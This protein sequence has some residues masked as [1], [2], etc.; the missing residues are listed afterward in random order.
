MLSASAHEAAIRQLLG[1]GPQSSRALQQQLGLSQP[2]VSR[3]LAALGNELLRLGSGRSSF[4]SLRDSWPEL[5]RLPLRRVCEAGRLHA[6][7][8]L[9]P[10]RPA[11]FAVAAADG[12]VRPSD[13]LPW[14]LADLRPQGFLGRAFAQRHAAALGL[15]AD[16][17]AW[18]DRQ[19]LRALAT[20]GHDAVGNLLVGDAAR[21]QFLALPPPQAVPSRQRGAVFA[22]RAAQALAGDVPGSSAGGE[23]PKFTRTW[24][25]PDGTLRPEL[26]KF[27][28]PVDAP[29][30]RRWADLLIAEHLAHVTL[31][32]AGLPA[33]TSR[34]VTA[35]GR[36][37]LC[38]DRFDRV[39]ARGRRGVASL[40]ALDDG[41]GHD[42]GRWTTV[43]A[44]LVATGRVAAAVHAQAAWLQAFGDAIANTDMHLGNLSLLTQGDRLEGLAPV[45]DMLPM[46][47]APR[48]GGEVLPDRWRPPTDLPADVAAAARHFWRRAADDERVSEAYRALATQRAA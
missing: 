25:H 14:W 3:A 27:S 39:G 41:V 48:F 31:A 2:T 26:V 20:Q 36:L 18:S 15:P 35:G 47:D 24:R 1:R 11:G 17:A 12:S 16:V 9:L 40:S 13:G 34:I 28:P 32:E 7:G 4:Y 19:V 45:Y 30:G 44:H 29:A 43:T 23:Q 6:L 46:A 8:E 37:F 33:S 10:L 5:P 42:V 38:V 21:E 22:Q